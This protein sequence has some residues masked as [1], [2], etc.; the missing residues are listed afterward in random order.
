MVAN[1]QNAVGALKTFSPIPVYVSPKKED[2]KEEKKKT[3][4]DWSKGYAVT[5]TTNDDGSLTL[6]SSVANQYAKNL[7]R[8]IHDINN[9]TDDDEF[10]GYGGADKDFYKT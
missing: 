6:D 10:L 1:T 2:K 5:Y 3:R 9:Y 7:L 4:K 8:R